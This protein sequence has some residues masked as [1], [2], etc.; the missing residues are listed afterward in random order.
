[1]YSEMYT[2]RAD[3]C[4]GVSEN[5]LV[6]L[7]G[8]KGLT[9]EARLEAL[10]AIT[11]G[12]FL[13]K[14][15]ADGYIRSDFWVDLSPDG[16][17]STTS[18]GDAAGEN[19][20]PID[21]DTVELLT[22]FLHADWRRLAQR[23]IDLH[24]GTL[25]SVL[26][27]DWEAHCAE[28]WASMTADERK[29]LGVEKNPQEIWLKSRRGISRAVRIGWIPVT[30]IFYAL[31]HRVVEEAAQRHCP[32]PME[33][34]VLAYLPK[35]QYSSLALVCRA[36]DSA[37]RQPN[38]FADPLFLLSPTHSLSENTT[39]LEKMARLPD[40]GVGF[41]AFGEVCARFQLPRFGRSL[42]PAFY[43]LWSNLPATHIIK[44]D[45]RLKKLILIHAPR[46][47]IKIK[48]PQQQNQNQPP[49][50]IPAPPNAAAPAAAAAA[51]GGAV[52]A[53]PPPP[54]PGVAQDD[55]DDEGVGPGG[56]LRRSTS[57]DRMP[58]AGR[59]GGS[60]AAGTQETGGALSRLS[61]MLRRYIGRYRTTDDL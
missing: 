29:R 25:Q 61:G 5:G 41:L 9:R 36:F 35:G 26:Q 22:K 53:L 32:I 42:T 27:R 16:T 17:D 15:D 57:A 47:T 43:T 52:P 21:S 48:T 31:P 40:D 54:V 3:S 4:G 51:A 19:I 39:I 38:L 10:R 49:P 30:S 33:E 37:V 1:M 55:D 34:L 7:P 8:L 58:R 28:R 23:L 59:R 11:T 56:C 45:A 14:V 46:I 60:T 24:T 2:V 18:G 44:K 6:C 20:R 12:P 50:A 13:P